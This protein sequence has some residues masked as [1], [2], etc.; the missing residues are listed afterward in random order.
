MGLNDVVSFPGTCWHQAVE[1]RN[2]MQL[3]RSADSAQVDECLDLRRLQ[4]NQFFH[5]LLQALIELTAQGSEERS[6]LESISNN[7]EIKGRAMQKSF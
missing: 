6:L 3:W 4:W 7:I 1:L 2:L 5:P